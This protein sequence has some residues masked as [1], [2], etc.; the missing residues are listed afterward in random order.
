[1]SPQG[2][3]GDDRCGVFALSETSRINRTQRRRYSDTKVF[4]DIY[5]VLLDFYLPA[6]LESFRKEF[7]DKVLWQLYEEEIAPFYQR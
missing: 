5:T 2:I 1:M 7:G 4:G 6:E 3:G